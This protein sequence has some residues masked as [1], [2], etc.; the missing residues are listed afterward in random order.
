MW[1]SSENFRYYTTLA[2]ATLLGGVGGVVCVT[3]APF[4]LGFTSIGISSGSF[5]ASLMSSAAIANGGGIA[6]GSAIAI[7]QSVGAA[8]I[9]LVGG[10]S[11]FAIG[12]GVAGGVSYAMTKCDVSYE[13]TKWVVAYD[14]HE[15]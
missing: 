3:T 4:A 10:S 2:T 12:S 1:P 11:A 6:A 5:A 14:F 8:G 13:M 15:N 7:C 9:G